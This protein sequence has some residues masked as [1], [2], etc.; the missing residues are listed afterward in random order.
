MAVSILSVPLALAIF[1]AVSSRWV[2]IGQL[3]QLRAVFMSDIIIES[4]VIM[5]ILL[6]ECSDSNSFKLPASVIWCLP[7]VLFSLYLATFIASGRAPFDLPE[8]ESELI[9]GSLTELG[10]V[11]FTLSYLA[12]LFEM[13]LIILWLIG[14]KATGGMS[15]VMALLVIL[16]TYLGRIILVRLHQG[17]LGRLVF[18]VLL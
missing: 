9:S 7:T 10:S 5:F 18:L 6:F 8:A 17:D 11:G 12:D 2:L 15:T 13:L 4:S 14:L 1:L 3:R 16:S